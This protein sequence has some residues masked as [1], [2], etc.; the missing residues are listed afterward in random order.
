M[1]FVVRLSDVAL[2]QIDEQIAWYELKQQGLGERFHTVVLELVYLFETSPFAQVRYEK[3][4]CV[5]IKGFPYM[6]HIGIDEELRI[7]H[8]FALIHTARNPESNWGK[9]D[10]MFSESVYYYGLAAG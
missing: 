3:V 6:F 8:I 2:Q 9:D 5:P 1:K 7:V 10:W 4:R